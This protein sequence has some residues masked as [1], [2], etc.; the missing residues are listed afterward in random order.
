[1]TVVEYKKTMAELF[2]K[3][4]DPMQTMLTGTNRLSLIG[5]RNQ[6]FNDLVQADDVLIPKEEFLKANPGASL[7]K[8]LKVSLEKQKQAM[9]RLVVILR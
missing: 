5:R 6:F 9:K 4:S 2:G 8:E 3:V 7:P 1:M